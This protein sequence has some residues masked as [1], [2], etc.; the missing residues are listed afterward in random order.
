MAA[1]PPARD[2]G[3]GPRPRPGW[4]GRAPFPADAPPPAH[5]CARPPL[6]VSKWLTRPRRQ[7]RHRA[8]RNYPSQQR[9]SR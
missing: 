7:G 1:P 9:P 4:S 8:G 5:R 6:R 3:T 2:P